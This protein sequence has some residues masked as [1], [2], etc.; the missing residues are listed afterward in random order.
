MDAAQVFGNI[1]S[2]PGN[3]KYHRLRMLNPKVR[4]KPTRDVCNSCRSTTLVPVGLQVQETVTAVPGGLDLLV[5]AS[6][7]VLF[8]PGDGEG[9]G[10]EGW[11][12]WVPGV[13]SLEVLQVSPLWLLLHLTHV[14]SIPPWVLRYSVY[15]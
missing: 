6:F 5:A 15:W 13:S 4:L 3:E 7:E 8:E 9:A 12:V 10:E 11:A 2:N 1:L 14:C